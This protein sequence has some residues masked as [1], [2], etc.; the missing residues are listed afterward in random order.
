MC[1]KKIIWGYIDKSAHNKAEH[2]KITARIE[3]RDK[4]LERLHKKLSKLRYVSWIDELLEPIAKAM[5]EKM[6][7]R[8][9]DI[10]GPFGLGAITSIHFYKNGTE[11]EKL[12]S[13]DNCRSITFRPVD[14]DKGILAIVDYT[15]ELPGYTKG[16]IGEMSRLQY[17]TIPMGKSIDELLQFMAQQK[18]KKV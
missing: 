18:T 3:Q 17:P 9:Y 7:D 13:G 1:L 6:P 16:S 5:V 12:F 14:L 4:Q 10:L 15:R 2:A 8:Y 11:R